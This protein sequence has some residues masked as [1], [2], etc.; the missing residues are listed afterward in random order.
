[1]PHP[2]LESRRTFLQ[3]AAATIAGTCLPAHGAESGTPDIKKEQ[4]TRL[5]KDH[6]GK[7]QIEGTLLIATPDR[8]IL[9]KGNGDLAAPLMSQLSLADREFIKTVFSELPVEKELRLPRDVKLYRWEKLRE[10][11]F[12]PTDYAF[13]NSTI[14]KVRSKETYDAVMKNRIQIM[15]G[16]VGAIQYTSAPGAIIITDT[17]EV[18]EK[19]SNL[20]DFKEI[21]PNPSAIPAAVSSVWN[22]LQAPMR[23]FFCDCPPPKAIEAFTKATGFAIEIDHKAIAAGSRKPLSAINI[24]SPAEVSATSILDRLALQCGAVPFCNS[25]GSGFSFRPS[26]HDPSY[27]L[28]ATH[29]LPKNMTIEEV[30]EFYDR[31]IRSIPRLKDQPV[32][33]RF[34][35]TS[36]G[37]NFTLTAPPEDHVYLARTLSAFSDLRTAVGTGSIRRNR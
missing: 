21:P 6:S 7:F 9:L 16:R 30:Q 22:T 18:H 15:P 31:N 10:A 37:S 25:E 36:D 5:W 33:S 20:K 11:Q 13:L 8:A 12:S 32:S 1:M 3:V 23:A 2:D 27:G 24:I 35:E 4:L 26:T 28:K 14:L 19:I 34:S 29:I 17:P